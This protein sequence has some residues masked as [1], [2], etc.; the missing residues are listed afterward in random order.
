MPIKPQ[1]GPWAKC[2]GEPLESPADQRGYIRTP[3]GAYSVGPQSAYLEQ[4]MGIV[5]QTARSI[6]SRDPFVGCNQVF[7]RLRQPRKFHFFT[8][9]KLARPS[10]AV[11]SLDQSHTHSGVIVL[12]LLR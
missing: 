12:R 10:S 6:T 7:Y 1:A 2:L 8:V 4:P 11:R 5:S 9:G 3:G